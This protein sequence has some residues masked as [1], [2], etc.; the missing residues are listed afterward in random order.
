MKYNI[1]VYD[2]YAGDEI[3]G[4]YILKDAFGKTTAAGKAYL[5]GMISD[6]SGSIDVKFWDYTGPVSEADAGKVV[7]VHGQ[8]SE[9]KGALQVILSNIRI[10]KETDDY[11]LSELVPVAPI[12]VDATMDEV[13]DFIA[14]IEDIDYRHVAEVMFERHKDAFRKIPAAKSVHHSFVSGLLMH[15]TNMLRTADFLS[16][17]YSGVIDRSLLLTGTLLHDFAKEKEFVF[18]DLGIVKDYSVAG[19]LLGHLVMGAMEIAEV[20]KAENIPENKS[21]LLQHMLL[22]HHGE[23]ERGAALR[24]VCAE[25]ELLSYIDAIDSRMEIYEE[26]FLDVP[27]GEFSDRVF[28]LEKKIYNHD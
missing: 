1:A 10:A 23:P 26:T 6:R 4:Y 15:T 5:S 16:G 19:D 8:V 28:A 24:P 13:A 18:S 14:S 12:D 17:L 9:Y 20:C 27:K 7:K 11:D 22:S 25:A 3:D 2:M 21:L